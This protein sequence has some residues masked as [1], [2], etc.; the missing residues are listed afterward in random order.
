M[1][2]TFYPLVK[3]EGTTL[4]YTIEQK[5]SINKIEKW[6]K[7]IDTI[8][9]TK[10]VDVSINLHKETIDTIFNFVKDIKDTLVFK[11]NNCIMSGGV[12]IILISDN[13]FKVEYNL[14]NTFDSTALSIC[15]ILNCY[16]PEKNK[17]WIEPDFIKKRKDCDIYFDKLIEKDKAR[18]LKKTKTKT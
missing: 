16:L 14:M 7:N 15:N 1:G 8:W 12:D 11:S 10:T 3:I 18:K 4:T 5:T 13:S 6:R 17:I 9:N 2:E